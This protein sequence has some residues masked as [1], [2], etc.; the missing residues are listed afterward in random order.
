MTEPSLTGQ[1]LSTYEIGRLI[2]K[3]GG[4]AVYQARSTAPGP[5]G[6]AG[7][8]VAIKIFH[9]DLITDERIFQRFQREAE[10][11]IRI[12]HEHIV[13][14]YEVACEEIEGTPHHFMAMELVEGE[15]LRETLSEL[16]VLP[17]H[18][19]YQ[20]ADQVLGALE[21]VH[22][23]GMIHRDI[24]PEN[25]VLTRDQQVRVMDLGVA[26]LQQ[27]GRDLTRA[28]EF[29]GSLAY[30]APEQFTDQ[31][32]VD[33]RADIYA[34]GVLLYEIATGR[35]PYD[36]PELPLL[37]SQKIRGQVRRPKAVNRDLD[38][39][40][41]EVILTCAHVDPAA[42]FASCAELR[43]VLKEGTQSEW[44]KGRIEGEAFP[45]ATR[46]L[47]RL[48]PARDGP[49][50]GRDADLERLHGAYER[51]RSGTGA[52]AFVAG[53]S[54]V[55]KSRLVHDF[56]EELVAPD[57]PLIW[58][59][60]CPEEAGRSHHALLEAAHEFFGEREGMEPRLAELLPDAPQLVPQ[61][62]GHLLGESSELKANDL[63]S[64]YT[65]MLRGLVGERPLVLVIEDLHRADPETVALFDHLARALADHAV[66]LLA[67]YRA[68]EVE[69]GS[70]LH[71]LVAMLAQRTETASVT[72]TPLDRDAAEELLQALVRLPRTVRALSWPLFATSDGNPHFL[73]EILAHLK[74]SGALAETD[75]GWV[76]ARP[77]DEVALPRN[78]RTLL[79]LKLAGLDDELTETLLAAAVQGPEFDASL[80]AAVTKQKRIRLLKRLA[81]LERKHRLLLSAGKS[82]FRFASHGLQRVVYEGMPEERR[83]ELHSACADAIREEEDELAGARAHEWVRHLLLAGRVAQAG[84]HAATAIEYVATHYHAAEGVVFLERL[85]SALG[86]QE[87]RL[88]F[89]ALMRL[90]GLHRLLGRS[91]EQQEALARA[92]GEA[93]AIGEPGPRARVQAALAAASWDAGRYDQAEGEAKDGLAL[94]E[95]GDDLACKAQCLHTLGAVAYRRGDHPRSVERWDA[96]LAIRREIGD[97]RGEARTLLRMGAVMPEVGHGDRALET[98]QEALAILREIGDRRGEGAA[99][100]NVGNALVETERIHEALVCYEQSV[101]IARELGDLPAQAAAL[102]N[103]AR[104]LSIEARVEEAKETFEQALDIYREIGDPSGEA[105]VLDELGS[106]VATFG[107]REEALCCL[108]SAREAAERTGEQAL[109]ARVLRHL[110]N[111]HHEAGA[112]EEAWQLFERALGLART[113]TRSAILAD[114][115]NAA[116]REGDHDR[117]AELLKESLAGAERGSRLLR[118]L[119]C[120]ARAHQAAGRTEDALRC[121]RRAAEMIEGDQPVAPHHGPEIYYSLGTVLA[122]EERGREYLEQASELLRERTRS[123]RSVVYREHYLTTRWPNREILEEARRLVAED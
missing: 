29:V 42:R 118:S 107:D 44:W 106:T 119:C 71:T 99:L 20:V 96:A 11:G 55:G 25:I 88:R 73:L 62:A 94:A 112:R 80:L 61:L 108:E 47:A 95:Q 36:T 60:R 15:T 100:N 6:E 82:A 4:G 17:E 105:G 67:S 63:A 41:D 102:Y 76:P 53:A 70:A 16:G 123:I 83:T 91:S 103:T 34:F 8:V 114:M 79:S 90:A 111:V 5:A 31:D 46:A 77:I 59:G 116:E 64:A 104:V 38:P 66:L 39:F 24:K 28:G 3:G 37:I 93:D 86:E 57:G 22:A 10:L 92:S 1:T 7:A 2:G 81:L 98:K 109:L 87:L 13:P 35:N 122:G 40:L 74:Q 45:T 65:A 117:A 12:R 97:R 18:L 101:N 75:D 120:L 50:V 72:V 51:A 89:E 56:L 14:T 54:G 84:E 121:A 23:E 48:R 113:R 27:E 26:R 52:V 9:P 19:L 43:A 115:G 32:H 58:A 110:A 78:L 85:V 33:P 30:A 68:D 49:L 69:E 21:V